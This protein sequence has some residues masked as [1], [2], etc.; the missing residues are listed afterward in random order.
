MKRLICILLCLFLIVMSSACAQQQSEF[1]DPVAFYYLR[2][3]DPDSIHH[4]SIDSII[5]PDIREGHDLRGNT[6]LLL[7]RYLSGPVSDT[8][9]SPFP[10]GT[11]LVQYEMDGT[12]LSVTLSDHVARLTGMDLTLAC[13]CMTRTLL[14]LTDANAVRIQAETLYLDGKASITMNQSILVLLDEPI[15]TE[16][17]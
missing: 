8:C 12:T 5:A 9:R 10:V 7:Q 16:S 14:D 13:A 11:Y 1:T 15:A 6:E 3:Q 17:E 2:V 4:G